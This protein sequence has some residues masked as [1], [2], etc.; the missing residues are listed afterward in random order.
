MMIEERNVLVNVIRRWTEQ[1]DNDD[2][3][4]LLAY[5]KSFSLPPFLISLSRSGFL[6]FLLPSSLFSVIEYLRSIKL[7]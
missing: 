7:V 5:N 6:S 1:I 4:I 3:V 2:E